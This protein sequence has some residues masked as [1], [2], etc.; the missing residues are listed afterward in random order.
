MHGGKAPQVASAAE[1]RAAMIRAVN[2]GALSGDDVREPAVIL[3]DLFGRLDAVVQRFSWPGDLDLAQNVVRLLTAIYGA[4]ALGEMARSMAAPGPSRDEVAAEVVAAVASTVD[5][6][7][8]N[9]TELSPQRRHVLRMFAYDDLQ[10]LLLGGV[11]PAP[12]GPPD[13][14]YVEA[15][16]SAPCGG[17][18]FGA[19]H[20][21]RVVG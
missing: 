7:F 19:R 9:C 17:L 5:A 18:G 21:C 15:R 20:F 4:K 6:V 16:E 3:R 14:E 11:P 13:V 8:D 1:R 2:D 10:A 12:P